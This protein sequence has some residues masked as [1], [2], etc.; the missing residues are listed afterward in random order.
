ME[1][2]WILLAGV[3]WLSGFVLFYC[4]GTVNIGVELF[5]CLGTVELGTVVLGYYDLEYCC[6]LLGWGFVMV[7]TVFRTIAGWRN[8]NYQVP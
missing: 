5:W 8:Y 7:G 3:F 2:R 6:V 4:E 1:W